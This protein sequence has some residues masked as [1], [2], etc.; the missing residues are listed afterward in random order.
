MESANKCYSN[1]HAIEKEFC[2]AKL[3]GSIH[4]CCLVYLEGKK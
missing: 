3:H 2:G 1:A 4:D